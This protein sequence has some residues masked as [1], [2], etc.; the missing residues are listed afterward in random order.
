MYAKFPKKTDAFYF[1]RE[2]FSGALSQGS[3]QEISRE[4]NCKRTG[5]LLARIAGNKVM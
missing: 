1:C 3:E 5:C 4:H 2:T